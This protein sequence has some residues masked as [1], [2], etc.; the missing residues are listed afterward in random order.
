MVVQINEFLREEYKIRYFAIL[1]INE[2]CFNFRKKASVVSKRKTI[3]E[4]H[5]RPVDL[6]TVIGDCCWRV[7]DRYKFNYIFKNKYF[8]NLPSISEPQ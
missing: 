4:K 3:K 8:L 7:V 5:R 6:L 1:N 2:I